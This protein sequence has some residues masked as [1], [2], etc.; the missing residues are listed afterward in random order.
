MCT[1]LNQLNES[2]LRNL[3][4]TQ[5]M[6]LSLILFIAFKYGEPD[7]TIH[8]LTH[9]QWILLILFKENNENQ[10]QKSISSVN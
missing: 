6:Y 3:Q 10:Q 5:E 7:S 8:L 2:R 9:K 1:E 4:K